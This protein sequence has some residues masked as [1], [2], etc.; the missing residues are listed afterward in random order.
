MPVK[1]MK[2]APAPN[3]PFLKVWHEGAL[4]PMMGSRYSVWYMF[5]TEP[6]RRHEAAMINVTLDHTCT[7]KQHIM[8]LYVVAFEL[9]RFELKKCFVILHESIKY[10]HLSSL[11]CCSVKHIF[12]TDTSPTFVQ[13][14]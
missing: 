1:T 2:A 11:K 6:A 4:S 7:G 3:T 12:N 10:K 13:L 9:V 8:S 5:L 14:N